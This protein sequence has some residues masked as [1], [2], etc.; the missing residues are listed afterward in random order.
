MIVYCYCMFNNSILVLHQYVSIVHVLEIICT[1]F[2]RFSL[3]LPD[4]SKS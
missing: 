3:F 4:L 2:L 1:Y